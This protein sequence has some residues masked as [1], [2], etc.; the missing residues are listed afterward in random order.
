MLKIKNNL[1]KVRV[2]GQQEIKSFKQCSKSNNNL[3]IPEIHKFI[4][5]ANLLTM[6]L[7]ILQ[8]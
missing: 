2:T 5:S 7:E 1:H 3:W 8:L 6:V 4:L